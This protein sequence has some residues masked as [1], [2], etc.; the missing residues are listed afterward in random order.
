MKVPRCEASWAGDQVGSQ[1]GHPKL[2]ILSTFKG[3]PSAPAGSGA[4]KKGEN[5]PSLQTT[6]LNTTTLPGCMKELCLAR[7]K[8]TKTPERKADQRQGS[9]CQKIR[10]H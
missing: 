8:E 1:P 5:V 3:R 10:D 6:L 9:R 4:I 7:E 2:F